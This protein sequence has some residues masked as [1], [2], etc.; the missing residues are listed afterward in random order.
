[1]KIYT[2]TGDAGQTGLI[3]GARVGKDT[4]QMAAIGDVDELNA[5]LGIAVSSL[6]DSFLKDEL[7]QIQCRLFDL[8]AELAGGRHLVSAED[9]EAL[10]VSIDRQTA[11]LPP[12]RAFILPGG[13]PVAAAFH[14]ARTVCRR[15]ERS[16]LALH[17]QRPIDA[18]SL[19]FLNRLSDWLFTA[20]R[21]TNARSSVPDV[22]WH[23]KESR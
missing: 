22:E 17:R 10:E 12:L 23:A 8:G 18:I 16:V 6:T 4:L 20:A 21:T 11:G 9:V 13:T 5:C 2:R 7:E 3:G 19:A 14:L 1:M 15:A